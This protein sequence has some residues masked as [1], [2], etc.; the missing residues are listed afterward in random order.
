MPRYLEAVLCRA[1]ITAPHFRTEELRKAWEGRLEE[2]VME[3][4]RSGRTSTVNMDLKETLKA[5]SQF[6]YNGHIAG[7]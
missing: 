1:P 4:L 7:S 6:R 3:T 5:R 2:V